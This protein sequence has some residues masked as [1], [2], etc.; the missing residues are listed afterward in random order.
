MLRSLTT[1][2]ANTASGRLPYP[3]LT[4]A[5]SV[6]FTRK[7]L[8]EIRAALTSAA[9]DYPTAADPKEGHAAVL[10]PLCNVNDQPG[11]LL[12]LRGKLRKHSGEVSFPGGRVDPV[13]GTFTA[14]ALRETREEIG[15]LPDQV[16][17]LGRLGPPQ[18]SLSGL[19]V[20]PFVGFIHAKR[21]RRYETSGDIE[22]PLSSL[23]MDSLTPSQ[24][25]VAAA[26]HLPLAVAATPARLKV[27]HFRGGQAYWAVD[28]SDLI[29]GAPQIQP[30]H[31]SGKGPKERV[32]VWGITGWYLFLF[33][34]ALKI[35][36]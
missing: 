26:F 23:R 17:I 29:K 4:A 16:E 25:E 11:I 28:V 35:Y 18:L 27:D 12:E 7:S 1:T 9:E 31:T 20:W 32:E 36:E 19:R 10:I 3:N 15:I 33:M 30:S 34:K 8:T 6:P 2:S 21:W 13:D 22:A 14:T 24:S 5:L